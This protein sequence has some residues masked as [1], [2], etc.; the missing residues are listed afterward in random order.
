VTEQVFDIVIVGAGVVG[1]AIARD[2][3]GTG[4]TVALVDARSDICEGTS[5][6]NTALLSS[7]F[8]AAPD[9]LELH[10]YTRGQQ[11]L[12][13]YCARTGIAVNKVGGIVVAWDD[14]QAAKLPALR[15]I[16]HRNGRTSC[17]LLTREQVYEQ[18]PALAEGVTGGL[19]VPDEWVMDPWSA[20]L[21]YATD[22]VLRGAQLIVDCA[23]TGVDV[24]SDVTTVHTSRGE[25]STRWLVNA[26]GLG[27]DILDA[28]YGYDR[29]HL[30][31]RRG[32]LLIF[33]KLA[34]ALV[35]KIV[36]AVPTPV[37]KGVLITP[38]VF[39]NVL[40]GPNAEVIDDR[41]DTSTTKP[42][43]DHLLDKGLGMFPALADE[44]V[45]SA[46]AGLRA[47]HDQ[48]DCL[49]DVDAD[50]RYAIAAAFRSGLTFSMAIAET[51]HERLADSGLD[52][53]YRRDLPDPPSMPPL[54]QH[55]RR[56]YQ[57]ADLIAADPAYGDIVCFCER[58][59]RGEIRDALA[60]T[61]PARSVAGL[62]RRT[63]AM[64]GR[65]QGFY[66]GADVTAMFNDA[67]QELS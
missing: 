67:Q 31:P 26:A 49:I 47:G 11:L 35:P 44:E 64:N 56:P 14:E 8:D 27:G 7:G 20:P 17:E 60:S 24:G 43:F 62:R 5:K 3:A 13:E 22:A 37:T 28:A 41:T 45:T 42:V 1:C 54:G 40:V 18:M 2:L 36:L 39:G 59:T 30:F 32:E 52:L 57:D 58:V 29:I 61:L 23:V 6:A 50:Q 48:S 46:Y 55:Q 12:D 16:A 65:C 63:R 38:S 66:C 25:L 9:S 19:S 34:S 51:L 4:N 21:A 10:L 15:E 53:T 33:D